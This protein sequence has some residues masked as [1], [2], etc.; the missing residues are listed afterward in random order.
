MTSRTSTNG[1]FLVIEGIDG[2]GKTT[3]AKKLV[4]FLKSKKLKAEYTTEPT[5][6]SIYGKKL[7]ESFFAPERLSVEEEFRLF[8]EDRK[9]HIAKEVLPLI[10]QGII[11]VCDRYYFSSAAYQGSRGLDWKYILQENM[12]VVF[13]PDITFLIDIP[14]EKAIERI[15]NGRAGKINTF[16]K[17][18]NL[19]KVRKIYQEIAQ[20]FSELI[21]VIDGNYSIDTVHELIIEHLKPKLFEKN[22]I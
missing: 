6:W 1:L 12:K 4:E 7:R 5:H 14:V 22:L 8:L 19:I 9:E 3:Q 11:V 20:E 15:A 10:E 17:R 21:T 18:E 16:E 13:S 2:V